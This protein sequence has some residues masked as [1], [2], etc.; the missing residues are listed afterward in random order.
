MVVRPLEQVRDEVLHRLRRAYAQGDL[1]T[2]TLEHRVDAALLARSPADLADVT[3][4]LPRPSPLEALAGVLDRL[5]GRAAPCERI[6]FG[7]AT[8]PVA[9]TVR[10][11]ATWLVG[12]SRACDVVLHDPRVSRRHALISVRAG[13]CRIRNLAS[14]NGVEVNGRPVHGTRR[15]RPGDRVALG[16]GVDAVVR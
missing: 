2:G 6:V 15:L 5:A 12:R 1:R 8:A 10:K 11:S 14:T 16:G 7:E 9:L 3:W 4:D 13:R